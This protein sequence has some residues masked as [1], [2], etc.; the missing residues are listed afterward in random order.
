[1]A[2]LGQA[3]WKDGE[4][5]VLK[6]MYLFTLLC[7][8]CQ[9]IAPTALKEVAPKVLNK[10]APTAP[11]GPSPEISSIAPEADANWLSYAG[12]IQGH[13]FSPLTQINSQNIQKLTLA[14]TYKVDSTAALESSPIVVDGKLYFTE[15]NGVVNALDASTGK[16]L[17]QNKFPPPSDVKLCCGPVNRGLGYSPGKLFLGTLDAKLI[18]LNL[19]DGKVLWEKTV[20][21]YK[22]GYSITSAPLVVEDKVIVG[23]AGG[24]FSAAG[25]IVAYSQKDGSELWRFNT[26]PKAGTPEAE[27]WDPKLLPLC[28]AAPWMT[29]SYDSETRTLF[30]GTGNPGSYLSRLT[31]K[32]GLAQLY[33]DSLLAIDLDDGNLRWHKQLVNNDFFDLG[34]GSVPIITRDKIA[35]SGK[36][37]L[38]H[39]LDKFSG[40]ELSSTPLEKN[41]WRTQVRKFLKI[42]PIPGRRFFPVP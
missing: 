37:G 5:L 22:N 20:A 3:Y 11:N 28:G 23:T 13:R 30:W 32:K 14:W 8:S 10:P 39:I 17:W 27:T 24:D 7:V 31:V 42:F 4:A 35:I 34:L 29:G 38:F 15:P 26:C 2:S 16:L 6:Y 21:N 18:A 25:Q 33:G 36:H 12:N 40:K 41:N 9:S 19:S 1:M